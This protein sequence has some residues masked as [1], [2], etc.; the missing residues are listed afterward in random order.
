MTTQTRTE[1]H[2]RGKSGKTYTYAAFTLDTQWYDVPGSYIF[3]KLGADGKWYAIYVGETASLKSRL[4]SSHEKLPCARMY[5][6]THIHAHV[7]RGGK[8]AR[9]AEETDLRNALNPPCNKG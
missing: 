1:V 4:I 8:S 5:G 7:N 3:A 6:I 2:W 9:L